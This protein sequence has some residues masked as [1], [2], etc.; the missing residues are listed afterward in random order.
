MQEIKLLPIGKSEII[1][2]NLNE[3]FDLFID[4]SF[5]SDD[6]QNDKTQFIKSFFAFI[7]FHLNCIVYT[8]FDRKFEIE[9]F[10]YFNLYYHEKY[11]KHNNK[12]ES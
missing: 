1:V 11:S 7:N 4:S 8:R 3:L 6:L 5:Y 10:E 2:Y 9:F 12:K